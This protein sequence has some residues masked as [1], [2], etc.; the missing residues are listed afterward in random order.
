MDQFHAWKD[1]FRR[2][3]EDVLAQR[4]KRPADAG[5]PPAAEGFG[6][7]WADLVVPPAGAYAELR[8]AREL[9]ERSAP[10]LAELER[11]L[12][13]ERAK[14]EAEREKRELL[15]DELAAE[16]LARQKAESSVEAA[17]AG[18]RRAGELASDAVRR[19]E[20]RV[21]QSVRAAQEAR[22]DAEQAAAR[23]QD[24]ER[25]AL[26]RLSGLREAAAARDRALLDLD[27]A[28]EECATLRARTLRPRR[29]IC[30]FGRM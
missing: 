12:A 17:E 11:Q 3:V 8:E 23:V 16:T 30:I 13:E 21:E 15:K 27:S 19:A 5:E 29:T 26:S 25:E 4:R 20:E 2:E 14:L 9:L 24:A 1:D 22:L 7:R 10:R 28:R 18:A 6:G